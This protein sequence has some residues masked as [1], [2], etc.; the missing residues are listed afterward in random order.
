MEN[1]VLDET[2]RLRRILGRLVDLTASRDVEWTPEPP[3]GF[4]TSVGS[5]KLFLASLDADGQAPYRLA[6]IGS[7]GNLIAALLSEPPDGFPQDEQADVRATNR[8]LRQLYSV[9][10]DRTFGIDDALSDVERQLGLDDD[11]AE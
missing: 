2:A 6:L 7:S 3:H 1:Q 9:T 8:S 4:T 10:R 11:P 5:Q